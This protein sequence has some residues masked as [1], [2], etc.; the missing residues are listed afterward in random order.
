MLYPEACVEGGR[1]CGCVE[2]GRACGCGWALINIQVFGA[3]ETHLVGCRQ[4]VSYGYRGS[5]AAGEN[6][7]PREGRKEGKWCSLL[8]LF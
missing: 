3:T 8:N 2:G 1:A 5:E 4:V 6:V 7:V